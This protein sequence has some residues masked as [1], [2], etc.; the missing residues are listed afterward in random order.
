MP[1]ELFKDEEVSRVHE[2]YY[3]QPMCV[4]IQLAMVDL[5][6]DWSLN[7]AAV[8][9]HSS[10]EIAA[11]YCA[12]AISF[13]SALRIAYFRGLVVYSIQN[14]QS[15]A[16]GMM[17]VGLSA[18]AIKPYLDKFQHES[19]HEV[20][21]ACI[22]SPRN[23]TLAGPV[24]RLAE[25]K[26]LLGE[27]AIFT[28]I[29]DVNAAYHS[30]YMASGTTSYNELL[31][32]IDG[33]VCADE[34]ISM[35]S[36]VTGQAI[37]KLELRDKR[38]WISNLVS[39]VDFSGALTNLLSTG[40]EQVDIYLEIGPHAAMQSS[41]RESYEG[42]SFHYHSVLLRKEPAIDTALETMGNLHSLG[43]SSCLPQSK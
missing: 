5:L 40:K 41:I 3:S 42:H 27:D 38:Y 32:D 8:V 10:G 16:C 6:R 12:N 23:I 7:P 35:I 34:T 28:K 18:D 4:A 33:P 1:D 26:N 17:A 37:A 25:L 31:G 11:A 43:V 22:N 14:S 19:D 30:K 13:D 21:V 24:E 36:T 9:G 20:S 15:E 29:L 39:K 2:P